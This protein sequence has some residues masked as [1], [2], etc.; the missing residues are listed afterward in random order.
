MMFRCLAIK[1]EYGSVLIVIEILIGYT[2]SVIY[3]LRGFCVRVLFVNILNMYCWSG[4]DKCKEILRL[5]RTLVSA[6]LLIG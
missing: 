2:W 4:V 5:T 6:E 3:S 1:V